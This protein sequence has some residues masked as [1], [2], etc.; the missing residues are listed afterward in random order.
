MRRAE[1]TTL[2]AC[3][4]RRESGQRA[5]QGASDQG[6]GRGAAATGR[7][8]WT[9]DVVSRVHDQVRV[10]LQERGRLGPLKQRM[11][12]FLRG[13]WVPRDSQQ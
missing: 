8:L 9:R 6:E 1:E 7:G 4:W 3:V 10:G 2:A 11:L 5:R 13:I 12:L